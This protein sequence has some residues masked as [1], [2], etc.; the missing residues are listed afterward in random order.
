MNRFEY[1]GESRLFI[2]R[3]FKLHFKKEINLVLD[4]KD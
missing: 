1:Y 3:L 4:Y 2:V